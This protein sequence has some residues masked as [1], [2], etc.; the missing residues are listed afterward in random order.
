VTVAHE[1]E[2]DGEEEGANRDGT[3]IQ[4]KAQVIADNTQPTRD[5]SKV[6]VAL[7]PECV[8]EEENANKDGIVIRN[9]HRT[10][11]T[12]HS[13][14]MYIKQHMNIELLLET[15]KTLT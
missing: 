9:K 14:E 8:D 4:E 6:S 5:N 7:E 13:Q 12:I 11:Q 2:C 1:Q 3:V 10:L 15:R